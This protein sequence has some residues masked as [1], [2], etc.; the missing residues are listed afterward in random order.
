MTWKMKIAKTNQNCQ[1]Y[2]NLA[3]SR[4]SRLV[5]NSTDG[6]MYLKAIGVFE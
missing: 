3:A 6:Y 2:V 1:K 4:E 5:E